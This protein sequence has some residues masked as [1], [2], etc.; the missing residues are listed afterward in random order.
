MKD[1]FIKLLEWAKRDNVCA[2][3]LLLGMIGAVPTIVGGLVRIANEVV[4]PIAQA[5]TG[6]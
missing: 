1:L 5:F 2:A 3:A 4:V 6:K